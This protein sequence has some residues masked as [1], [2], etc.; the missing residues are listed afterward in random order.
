MPVDDEWTWLWDNQVYIDC[1]TKNVR[2]IPGN[3]Q[4]EKQ[5]H[6][7]KQYREGRISIQVVH[8]YK[9]ATLDITVMS[10]DSLDSTFCSP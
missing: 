6:L 3:A 2:G 5:V 4:E 7:L 8:R 10:P 9:Q 1:F